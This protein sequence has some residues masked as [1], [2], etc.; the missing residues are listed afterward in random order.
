MRYNSLNFRR[1]AF[2]A[3]L[4]VFAAGQALA[5]PISPLPPIPAATGSMTALATPISPLPPI[6][7]ALAA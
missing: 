7:A 2:G 4:A 6:P 3:V 5:T 1:F